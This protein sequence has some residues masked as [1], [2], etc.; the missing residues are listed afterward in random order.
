[1][2]NL[3]FLYTDEQR[4]DTL[5]AYGNGVIQT[6]NLDRLA[7][8]STLFERTYVTQPVCTPSRS[9]LLTGLYP[10]QNGCTANNV[11]LPAE[12]PCLPEMLPPGR[13]AAAHHGKWHLGD[14]IWAQ[15]GFDHWR[16]IE[17]GYAE[18][19]SAGR[20]ADARSSYHHWLISRGMRP[21]K[22]DRFSRY[23][24]ARFPEELSKAAYLAETAGEFIRSHRGRPW[25]LFVNFLQ[26]HM[27]FFGPRD[28]QY[29]PADIPL[30][31]NFDDAPTADQPLKTRAFARA[32]R[33]LGHSGLPL[34]T[35]DDWRRMI[36]N[37]YGLVSLVDTHVGRIL[38]ALDE[39]GQSDE[40]VV[41]Y[42]SDH[43]DMM[44]SH[45]LL[46]KCVLFEEALRVPLLVRLPGQRRARRVAAPV[47]HVDLA[48]TLTDLLGGD[49]PAD[50]PGE[51][52]RG[53]LEGGAEPAR[54]VFVEWNGTDSGIW[55]AAAAR[56]WL[57]KALPQDLADLGSPEQIARSVQAPS[58][59]VITP[60]GWKLNVSACGEHELYDLNAD[61]LETRNLAARPDQRPRMR[62]L[63]GRIRQWQR[64]TGDDVKLP[65]L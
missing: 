57:E 64:R 32:Y 16:A 44:G 53:V 48:P 39:T 27:P 45:R 1:M 25:V 43:G 61:G 21:E 26:P 24:A 60:D 4:A 65:E 40:T 47:G 28:G 5:G 55:D 33:E 3:L 54:D 6:P 30:P 56:G 51:S 62:E 42:T 12:V 8:Q 29:D 59:T 46:A 9:S 31:A 19:F 37:Y 22:R 13:Y 11:P 20:D 49:A 15:H 23:E 7:S 2:P 35:T 36:A 50:L 34:R 10:H 18:Y 52:L 63:L 17:D 14:E 58:R 41:V 38:D